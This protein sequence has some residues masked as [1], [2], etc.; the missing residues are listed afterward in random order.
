MTSTLW[1]SIPITWQTC[2]S[3]CR[4]DIDE[5]SQLLEESNQS[6]T[7][8]VPA[9]ENIFAALAVAPSDVSVVILGQDP[10]PTPGHAIG[11]AFAVPA[12]TQ[13]LPGSLRNVFKEVDSDTGQSTTADC[14]LKAWVDQGVL[15]LNTSLTTE[16]GV[17]AGHST[18]PWEQIV[19]AL[20]K[21]VVEMNPK[22]AAILWGNHAEQFASLFDPE[23]IVES[24]HPS[25]LSASRGFLGSK[26]F[27]KVNSILESNQK[28]VINW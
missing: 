28:P 24:A 13:P 7:G 17:R 19:K 22:V 11:L 21:Y 1:D 3:Q 23:S 5:I 4:S 10:Y 9:I 18:W 14:S 16:T 15:L 2:L 12:G 6:G 27:S 25:P 26:P 20:L 8:V